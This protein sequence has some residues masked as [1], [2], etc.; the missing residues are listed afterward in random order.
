MEENIEGKL[1][2]VGPYNEFLDIIHKQ[3]AEINK[4]NYISLKTYTAKEMVNTVKTQSVEK[5]NIWKL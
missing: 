2:A 1:H 3:K 4:W 5:E